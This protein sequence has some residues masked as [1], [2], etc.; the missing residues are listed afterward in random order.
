MSG[1]VI[2]HNKCIKCLACIKACPFNALS[3]ENDKIEVNAACRLCKVC[4]GVCPTQAISLQDVI[5]K[6][7]D[8]NLYQGILVYVEHTDGNIH[9][10][11]YE[12]IGK[13]LEL[14]KKI[15]QQVYC[16]FIGENIK[17]KAN[18]LLEY[19]VAKVLVYDHLDL[20]YFRVD[21]YANVFESAIKK[22]MPN[23]VLVGAT[24]TGRS[25]A[26]RVAV[27]FKTGLTADTTILQMRENT[28]LVQIR[29]AFGGNIMAQI[30]TTK[31]RPQFATVR[32][33]VMDAP[34]KVTN[35]TG[36]IEIGVV[37]ESMLNSKI[38]LL[39]VKRKEATFEISEAE[40][41]V[42][43]GNGVKDEKGLKLVSELAELL[44]GVVGMT[45]PM[46]EKGIGSYLQQIGLS[47]R[48]VKPK[49]I[50]TC[51]VSGAIQFVAGMDKSD[52]IIAINSDPNAPI[53]KTAHYAVISDL[54]EVLPL[55]IKQIK[56]EIINEL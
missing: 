11:T 39:E 36:S 24:T 42:V 31:T 51:G 43:A 8:K 20:R 34:Q 19:G 17:E 5:K 23:T 54:Y 4:I 22:L 14:A 28:D 35:V 49:L 55:L 26:P 1:I 2:D 48:S 50:I 37:N 15:D 47:G 46:I 3:L 40:V 18:V 9:P 44:D 52:T 41:V 29:P 16:L 7:I 38:E 45:R 12:L 21:N 13:A 32:Y 53:F 6:V 56:G 25:L 30:L 33:K 27:R 10:V